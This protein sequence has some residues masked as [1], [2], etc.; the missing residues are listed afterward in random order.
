MGNFLGCGKNDDKKK[1]DVTYGSEVQTV[2]GD[3]G[4]KD[5]GITPTTSD[6]QGVA[7]SDDQRVATSDDQRVATS[8]DQGVAT[9]IPSAPLLQQDAPVDA[10]DKINKDPVVPAEPD[11]AKAIGGG[12][13]RKKKRKTKKRRK[14]SL[15]RKGKTRQKPRKKSKRKTKKNN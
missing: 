2:D 3:G 11:G 12:G 9:P 6:D 1:D 5:Q 14:G 13:K 4:K 7:T 15:R 10:A 8:D